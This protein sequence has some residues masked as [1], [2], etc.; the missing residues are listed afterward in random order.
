MR[1]L[2]ILALIVTT[3]KTFGQ[4]DQELAIQ[5]ALSARTTTETENFKGK[6]RFVKKHCDLL[7]S[8]IV[9]SNY[10]LAKKKKFVRTGLLILSFN[11]EIIYSEIFDWDFN[12]EFTDWEHRTLKAWSREGLSI[13]SINPEYLI[14]LPYRSTFGYACGAGAGMPKEGQLM[15]SHVEEKNVSELKD[16]LNSINPVLQGYAYLGFSLLEARGTEI[17]KSIKEKMIE[18]K[19]SDVLV[20]SCSGCTVWEP[21]PFLELLTDERVSYFIKDNLE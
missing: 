12:K 16:W 5:N 7:N 2:L 1:F 21:T 6:Y 18:L 3:G 20:Y 8:G 10:L 19:L 15:M 11:S 9:Q 4:I 17:N 14:R 13:D